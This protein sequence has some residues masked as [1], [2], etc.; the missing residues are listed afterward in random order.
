MSENAAS[1]HFRIAFE[2]APIG[3][4]IMGIR[5]PDRGRFLHTNPALARM[6]GCEP[7]DLDGLLA[8]E[9]SH[10]DDV[11][12][13]AQI[14]DA[15][16]DRTKHVEKRYMHRDGRS[17]WTLI[18]ATEAPSVDGVEPRY[19]VAQVVDISER[20]R[21]EA[22]LRYL[23]D[24]DSLTGLLN[25]RSFENEL[26]ARLE[27]VRTSGSHGALLVLDLDGFKFVNDRFGHAAG[28]ELIVKM[29]VLLKQCARADDTLARLGGDEFAILAFDC[30]PAAAVVLAERILA[31][32]RSRGIV[33]SPHA[34]A[35][36]TASVGIVTLDPSS[37]AS[38]DE[39]ALAADTAMY[40]AKANGRNG[41]AIHA[42][43][44]SGRLP[45]VERRSSEHD[46]WFDRLRRALDEDRFVLHAQPVVP[47]CAEGLDHYE[48]LLRLRGDGDELLPPG[49]FL[50]NAA[51]FDLI[52]EVDR[53]VLGQAARLLR[54]HAAAGHE[55][56]LAVNL[57][58]KTLDDLELAGELADVLQAYPVPPGRLAIEVTETAAIVN[59][60]SA[61][62]L[63]RRLHTLG[64]RLAL[65][66][67]GA[68]LASFYYLKHL[69]FDYLKIDGEFVN[70][71]VSGGVDRL[72]VEA[73]VGIARGLGMQTVAESVGD[74]ATVV[75]L[76]RLGVDYGQGFHLGRPGPLEAVL[77]PLARPAGES[78]LQ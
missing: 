6:L 66:D 49:A 65:A 50:L 68:G 43:E 14:L 2:H 20:K 35:R 18:S 77:P 30:T 69:Q 34:T 40:R 27:R 47:I 10:P 28:D 5:E 73:I 48:L 39:L 31:L 67:F 71:L 72:V 60:D 64:C 9:V 36:V 70:G 4:A 44:P 42:P 29:A 37:D 23:A 38:A 24:H 51:R 12:L 54:S 3:L 57:S 45:R 19:C 25:R 74:A 16:P 52:G 76:R 11:D 7:G 56:S 63:A 59:I 61:R 33:V 8:R 22:Q 26:V 21:I 1:E 62:E 58:G 75:L 41:Y 32:V 15:A 13:D 78:I 17:I 46:S 53:W 55:L